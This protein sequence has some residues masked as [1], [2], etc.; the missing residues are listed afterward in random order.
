M[1][2]QQAALHAAAGWFRPGA[3]IVF[4]WQRLHNDGIVAPI[5]GRPLFALRRFLN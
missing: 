3:T 5:L 4:G 1:I 2:S